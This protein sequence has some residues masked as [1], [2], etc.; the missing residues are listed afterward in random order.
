VPERRRA[1]G[2][3]DVC[4]HNRWASPM[5]L[6]AFLSPGWREYI[7]R[8]GLL[9]GGRGM[10]PL[11]PPPAWSHPDS[12]WLA[13]APAADP[14]ALDAALAERGVDRAVLVP[15]S[16]L[17]AGSL[18]H[19]AYSLDLVRAINDW[20]VERWLSAHPRLNG[21][22]L[23][24]S[25]LAEEAV[26]E[27]RRVGA[28][29]RMV[30]VLLSGGGQGRPFGHPGYHPIYAAAAELGLPI[31]IHTGNEA[32]PNTAG[33]PAAGG[34]PSTFGEYYV[35]R[36]QPIMTHLMSMVTQG[37]LDRH[38]DLRVVA[39]GA[40]VAWLPGWLWRF[41]SDYRSYASREA[42]WMKRFP[43]EQMVEQVRIATYS[44]GAI[45]DREGFQRLLASAEWLADTLC[46]GGGF[47][48]WDAD[49]PDQVAAAFPAAWHERILH[50]NALGAFRWPDGG[51]S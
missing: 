36:A 30:G 26:K 29:P 8:P 6:A 39:L 20:T 16:G 40:G 22:V 13:D 51:G 5:E 12:D 21:L 9:P 35:L 15:H 42:P 10:A 2:V 14:A 50:T 34:L 43:S 4:V 1:K 32:P 11:L 48:S 18:P 24:P 33:Q 3:I 31:V 37:V 44:F 45:R 46:Y 7:G 38:R 49:R 25:Q 23:A 41:D 17:I 28:H 19:A 27:V 47:P